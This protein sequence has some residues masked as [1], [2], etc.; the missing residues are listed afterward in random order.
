VKKKIEKSLVLIHVIAAPVMGLAQALP[1]SIVIGASPN[2]ED[3][4]PARTAYIKIMTNEQ[5]LLGNAGGGPTNGATPQQVTNI[6]SGILAIPTNAILVSASK[7]NDATAAMGDA[8]HPAKS[9]Q[10]AWLFV[11]TNA[12]NNGIVIASPGESYSLDVY[13]PS[14]LTVLAS[15]TVTFFGRHSY[16]YFTNISV[17][18][19]YGI[20]CLAGSVLSNFDYTLIAPFPSSPGNQN[21]FGMTTAHIWWGE[22]INVSG[23]QDTFFSA[24]M[25]AAFANYPPVFHC[26]YSHFYGGWD[27]LLPLVNTRSKTNAVWE[28]YNNTVLLTNT[29][30]PGATGMNGCTMPNITGKL[31]FKNNLIENYGI[32]TATSGNYTNFGIEFPSIA[33]GN[34]FIFE[35]NLVICTN[36]SGL[37]GTVSNTSGVFNP[38]SVTSNFTQNVN[39]YILSAPTNTAA[40]NVVSNFPFSVGTLYTNLTAQKVLFEETWALQTGTNGVGGTATAELDFN[41]T[42]NGVGHTFPCAVVAFGNTNKAY[43]P[44]TVPLGPGDTF[45]ASTQLTGNAPSAS[46]F[47]NA[48]LISDP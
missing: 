40:V 3:G 31:V 32:V 4:D 23:P 36:Y 21:P 39:C 30:S 19:I 47:Q 10:Y 16:L 37:S 43:F 28:Y 33:S 35:N 45:E 17:Q 24:S 26:A 38:I 2:N 27:N 20:N 44:M 9:M 18:P 48:I 42:N 11:Q 12:P 22:G 25:G 41:V 13:N 7:G 34:P 1:N 15:N 8:A 14:G 29:L 6:V 5:F 46:A